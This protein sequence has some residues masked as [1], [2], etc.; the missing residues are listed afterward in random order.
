LAALPFRAARADGLELL[1][2]PLGRHETRRL[3]LPVP[4]WF[5]GGEVSTPVVVVAGAADGPVLCLTGGI[6]GDELNGVEVVRRA[7]E[8]TKPGELRGTLVERPD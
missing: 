6:H 3:S 1:G 4:E 7:P 8:R 5:V 2:Q